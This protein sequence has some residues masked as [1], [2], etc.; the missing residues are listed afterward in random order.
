MTH[1][2]THTH[3]HT[4]TLTHTR[5]HTHTD[6]LH[7]SPHL[8]LGYGSPA[9]LDEVIVSEDE[10]VYE[11]RGAR[12]SL[13]CGGDEVLQGRIESDSRDEVLLFNSKASYGNQ[14]S[15]KIRDEFMCT[16][17]L[18]FYHDSLACGPLE[19]KHS[20]SFQSTP[21]TH[22]EHFLQ[23]KNIVNLNCTYTSM[24]LPLVRFSRNSLTVCV[25]ASFLSSR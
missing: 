13:G 21:D 20:A 10:E 25:T 2:H 16:I 14:K 24:P 7:F 1:T 15:P 9:F 11:G 18:F 19:P 3:T 4:C 17:V 12:S 5:A 23:R 22:Y 8:V 6:T